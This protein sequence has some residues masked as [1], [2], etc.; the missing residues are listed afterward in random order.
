M[1]DQCGTNGRGYDM[2]ELGTLTLAKDRQF[3]HQSARTPAIGSWF[4]C[5]G[6]QRRR[7]WPT[8]RRDTRASLPDR[9]SARAVVGRKAPLVDD[10]LPPRRMSEVNADDVG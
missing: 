10:E 2:T 3:T 9:R 1:D 4:F 6:V 5:V 7:R 8:G